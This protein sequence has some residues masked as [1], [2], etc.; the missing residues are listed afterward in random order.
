MPTIAWF[1]GIAIR[2]YFLDHPPPHFQAIY[3]EHEAN[4][5]IATGEVIDGRLPPTA[6]RLVKRWA[7]MHRSELQSNWDRARAKLP[8]DRIAGLDDDQ[9]LED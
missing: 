2:M 9:G 1:Y 4:V 6:S 8:L 7:V 5:A 3:G